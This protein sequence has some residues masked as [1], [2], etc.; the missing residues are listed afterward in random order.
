[1]RN[2]FTLLCAVFV[3]CTF[4][5]AQTE[6]DAMTRIQSEN[7]SIATANGSERMAMP[8]RNT[9]TQQ[10]R[11]MWDVEFNFS[12]ADSAGSGGQAGVV[13]FNNEFWTSRWAVDTLYRYDLNGSLLSAFT[14]AQGAGTVSGIRAMTTD[15]TNIYAVNASRTVYVIDPVAR[16]LSSTFTSSAATDLRFITYD[17]G[18]NGGAGGFWVG[19]FN[20]DLFL[21]SRTGTV[22]RQ[23]AAAT[24]RV[25]GMYGAAYDGVSA[26]GPFLWLFHQ[27]GGVS[28]A[29]ISQVDIASG[30]QTGFFREVTGDLGVE[31]DDLAG[32]LFLT[33]DRFVG[34]TTLVGVMQG[35]DNNLFGYDVDYTPIGVDAAIYP[36]YF[37]DI[38][39]QIP[40]PMVPLTEF[41]GQA[42]MQGSQNVIG[43]NAD[44]DI[45]DVNTGAS[46]YSDQQNFTNLTPATTGAISFTGYLPPATGTFDMSISLNLTNQVDEDL[47]NNQL[48]FSRLSITDSV[49]AYDDGT[50]VGG[51]YTVSGTGGGASFALVRY[52]FPGDA[53]MKALE[54]EL[55]T[56]TQGANIYPILVNIDPVTLEPF[57]T[58][59]AR[60]PDVTL[61]ASVNRYVL[62]FDQAQRVIAGEY[63][64]V[65]V[66]EAAGTALNIAQSSG[67]FR[68]GTNF[69]TFNAASPTWSG[70]S[71]PTNRFVRPVIA[72][73][74]T[75]SV[76][77]GNTVFDANTNTWTANV[78]A[79]NPTGRAFYLWN[80]PA[81]SSTPSVTG[82]ASGEY[83]VVVADDLGC[84]DTLFF[85]L[86][87]VGLADD[88]A[89]QDVQLAPVP[90]Q[91]FVD[92]SFSQ[93][94]AQEV[95]LQILDLS[96]KV[97]TTKMLDA[98][99]S[100]QTRVS[101]QDLA[102]GVY[103]LG[104]RNESGEQLHQRFSVMR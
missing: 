43:M 89:W 94:K 38:Y 104:L 5:Q 11:A 45:L 66:L 56:P 32:G 78:I 27:S 80:D 57:G 101:T 47:N 87:P 7:A 64:G 9:R 68:A 18:A 59:I 25:T 79:N 16:T 81:Q 60:G 30:T 100:V 85:G 75:F 92:V 71:I 1:M 65:G 88:L 96:G 12:A 86:Y 50:A 61:D 14:I 31:P 26:G 62:E 46:V 52:L 93:K 76:E 51:G 82:L 95:S 20:T 70:S 90:A 15:G 13:F 48:Q 2:L 8:L 3:C 83:R 23:V 77:L 99:Q 33:I 98:Q 10:S 53:Y 102:P 19:D 22:L 40:L 55:V 34:K 63:W 74:N 73:C 54:I 17:P 97:L 4:L 42:R 37:Q 44:F 24:H 35:G 21:I 29:N 36:A 67:N 72:T 41:S 39:T 91:D 103:I 49:L 84:V 58:P 6:Q 69:F 28:A